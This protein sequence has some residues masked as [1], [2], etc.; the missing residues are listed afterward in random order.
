MAKNESMERFGAKAAPLALLA[1]M[2][3]YGLPGCHVHIFF[4]LVART[5]ASNPECSLAPSYILIFPLP[6]PVWTS[7][8]YC[9]LK[10][11][12]CPATRYHHLMFFAYMIE[13][14][15]LTLNFKTTLIHVLLFYV[16]L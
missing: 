5:R 10:I 1:I 12:R 7:S 8:S 14:K 15:I 9:E 3:N 11:T 2:S 4:L 16:V 13:N 6:P